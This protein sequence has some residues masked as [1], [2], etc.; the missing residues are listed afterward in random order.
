MPVIN[1]T[2]KEKLGKT[3]TMRTTAGAV[4][5]S[6]TT[7]FITQRE[8]FEFVKVVDDVQYPG[9][10]TRK[11][12]LL[13]NGFYVNYIYPPNGLRA[14]ILTQPAE[15]PTPPTVDVLKTHDIE[16]YSDGSLVIDGIP[17]A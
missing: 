1:G 8:T 2:A 3:M 15:E 11:W 5:G 16:V 13:P 9:D 17:Y 12:F 10:A 4:A 6:G 14:D 7:S